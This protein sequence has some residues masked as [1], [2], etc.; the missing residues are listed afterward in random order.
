MDRRSF[1]WTAAAA[2]GWVL[3]SGG[4]GSRGLR[5][6]EESRSL[7]PGTFALDGHRIRFTHPAIQKPGKVLMLAD[8]HLFRQDDRDAEYRP[9][10][11]RMAAAYN[12]T[13]HFETGQPTDPE[14]CF[15]ETL[16]IAQA[17]DASLVALV[18]DILSFPSHAAVDWVQQ[19]LQAI[20]LPHLYV[21]G[22]HDW[23]YEGLP[24]SLSELRAHWIR[25]RLLPLY[26][27]DNP[28]M[29]TRLV[30]G[31]RVV[32]LDNS[33][34]QITDAQLEYFRRELATGEPVL[35]LVHIPLYAPL[36]P[37]GFGCGH[38]E[39][40]SAADR[41]FEL[42]RRERWPES[43][44]TATTFEFHRLVFSSP[45]VLGVLAGHIHRPSV[46]IVNGTPQVVTGHNAT[47][48]H[49]EIEFQPGR[50]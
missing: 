45:Q 37:V 17:A 30:S 27:A 11:A 36:R 44:H 31:V 9:Y 10:S 13:Q 32:A 5:A 12:H 28:L 6:A 8:T 50:G 29:T 21:A 3:S 20:G 4:R 26:G 19:Q 49:L 14:T 18:G 34:Y 47:G 7:R 41:N 23:H 43:G 38:P 39:W 48:A 16:K 35:L 46:D 1:C 40:G 24:G 33:N 15:Q 42:E 25:E 2:C 22:N